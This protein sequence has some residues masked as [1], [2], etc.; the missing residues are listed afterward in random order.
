M[1]IGQTGQ[2]GRALLATCPDGFSI[3]APE[4]QELCLENP[5]SIRTTFER[6]APDLVINTAAFHVV[7]SCE[8]DPGRAM[9]INFMAVAEL[10]QLCKIRGVRF[11][12]FSSDYVFDGSKGSPYTESDLPSP[13]QTYG[14]SRFAGECAAR[15]LW[16]DGSYIVRTCGV[17]GQGGS[18]SKGGN[19][20]LDRIKQARN[21]EPFA[22]S[23]EQIVSPTSA[24]SLALATW[25]LIRFNSPAGIYHLCDEGQCSWFEFTKE[26]LALCKIPCEVLP[27]DRN[28]RFDEVPRP[29]FSALENCAAKAL[30]IELPPWRDALRKFLTTELLTPSDQG[31]PHA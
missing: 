6:C 30:G 3:I 17:Y 19:F 22:V 14:V 28:G 12:T 16:T 24:K 26:I 7:R 11:V 10:A 13:L 5:K 20:V 9:R 15:S 4:R 25:K 21:L 1:L 2:L 27:I 8:G 29:L 23:S 31:H 18:R